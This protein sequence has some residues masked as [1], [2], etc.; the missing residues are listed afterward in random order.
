VTL[1][2]EN[3]RPNLSENQLKPV[4]LSVGDAVAGIIQLEDGR[5][6]LQQRDNVPHIWYPDC[7]GCFGGAAHDGEAPLDALHRELFEE[8][9]LTPENA[10]YFSRFDFDLDRIG[11]KSY[12]RT[13]YTIKITADQMN[14]L[15]LHEGRTVEAVRGDVIFQQLKLVPYDAFALFLHFAQNRIG[16]GVSKEKGL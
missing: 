8:L 11:L 16:S 14:H 4:R 2:N 9:E 6:L 3:E 10:T 12:Y 15:V 13:Y 7:W 5:Y 1:E